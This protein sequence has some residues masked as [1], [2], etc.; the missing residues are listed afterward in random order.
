MRGCRRWV[1]QIRKEAVR[2]VCYTLQA[3]ADTPVAAKAGEAVVAIATQ[4]LA[5]PA[6]AARAATGRTGKERATVEAEVTRTAAAALH[7]LFALKRLAPLLPPPAAAALTSPLLEVF[8]HG[9]PVLAQHA[10]V[11]LTEISAAPGGA[12]LEAAPLSRTLG[13][14]GFRI[15]PP[16]SECS[17]RT[18]NRAH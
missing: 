9:Q 8:S 14:V 12:S 3:L 11:A 13:K 4:A 6:L 5:A 17:V 18:L 16:P 15:V 2:A 7:C 10:V 1:L